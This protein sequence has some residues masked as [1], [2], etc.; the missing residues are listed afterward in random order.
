M[1]YKTQHVGDRISSVT[2]M[3]FFCPK[4]ARFGTFHA[5]GHTKKS[6]KGVEKGGAVV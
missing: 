4:T 6:K 2:Y 1:E 3:F 5:S